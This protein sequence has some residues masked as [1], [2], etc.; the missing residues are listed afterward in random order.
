MPAANFNWQAL[1]KIEQHI[2]RE[3]FES[4]YAINSMQVYFQLAARA[5]TDTQYSDSEMGRDAKRITKMIYGD[6]PTDIR[7]PTNERIE[8]SKLKRREAEKVITFYR[9]KGVSIPAYTTVMRILDEFAAVGW[10]L[11]REASVGRSPTL[12]FL[13]SDVR[14]ALK[15]ALNAI[16]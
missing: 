13:Q 15:P 6:K 3:L 5:I 12:Y 4:D 7:T 8:L 16:S 10:I 9:E 11:K 2:L 14:E 1:A